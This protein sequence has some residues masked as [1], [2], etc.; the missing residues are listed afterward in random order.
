MKK[1]IFILILFL[2]TL[3]I[4]AQSSKQT[5]NDSKMEETKESITLLSKNK[6]QWMS[7][8]NIDQLSLLFDSKA[9]FVHMGGTWGTERELEI[10]KSGW[11]WYK[12]ADLHNVSAEVFSKDL[13]IVWSK[14]TLLAVV[15]NNEVSNSFMVTEVFHKVKNEWKLADLTFSKLL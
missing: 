10:I 7:E 13:V 2:L 8:K 14:I 12:K 6:W 1:S 11:I 15:G 9:K 3:S 5:S 4:N